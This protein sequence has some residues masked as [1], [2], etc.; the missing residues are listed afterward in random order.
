MA[1]GIYSQCENEENNHRI[2]IPIQ[3]KFARCTTDLFAVI[4]PEV[5]RIFRLQ[6]EDRCIQK[7]VVDQYISELDKIESYVMDIIDNLGTMICD[8]K[9]VLRDYVHFA[10]RLA[11]DLAQHRLEFLPIQMKTIMRGYAD[12][13]IILEEDE[14]EAKDI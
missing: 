4:Y 6:F 14:D 12:S 10:V 3:I 1:Y 7:W 9:E 5:E 2:I 8:D 11:G 13:C